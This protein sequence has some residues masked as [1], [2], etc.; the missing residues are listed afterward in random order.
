MFFTHE[1]D[2]VGKF[3]VLIEKVNQRHMK[4]A[5][6]DDHPLFLEG[7]KFFLTTIKDVSSVITYKGG[8]QFLENINNDGM[9]D[10]IFMD[11]L[12][13][14]IDGIE[15]SKRVKAS[16]PSARIIAISSLEDVTY[17]EGMIAAGVTSYLLKDANAEELEFALKETINDRNYFSPKIL[18]GLTQKTVKWTLEV[19]TMIARISKREL[20]VLKLICT[21]MSR[22]KIAEELCIAEKTVDKHRENL[23]DKTCSENVIQLVLFAIRN[24]LVKIES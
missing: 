3:H 6:V 17:V 21:G 16:F 5:I 15:T 2:F 20:E 23:M 4:I 24:Q 11:I 13:P 12:M 7:L 19:Q 10:V 1:D 9:P 14:D 8:S 22:T 18:V